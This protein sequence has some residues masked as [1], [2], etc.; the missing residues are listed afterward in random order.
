MNNSYRCIPSLIMVISCFGAIM[1]AYEGNMKA[2]LFLSMLT[3]VAYLT[4]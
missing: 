1:A 2:C 3:A 4:S